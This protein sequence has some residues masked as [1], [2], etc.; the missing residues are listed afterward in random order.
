M[1]RN[2]PQ[3][4]DA[5]NKSANEAKVDE[6]DERSRL[7]GGLAAEEGGNRPSAGEHGDD[8]EGAEEDISAYHVRLSA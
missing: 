3:L 1:V 5:S 8:E 6:G 4:V 7:A 2:A